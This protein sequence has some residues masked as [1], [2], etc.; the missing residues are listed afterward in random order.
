VRYKFGADAD[1]MVLPQYGDAQPTTTRYGNAD[2]YLL[3]PR[4]AADFLKAAGFNF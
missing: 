4:I 3:P 1:P 2:E